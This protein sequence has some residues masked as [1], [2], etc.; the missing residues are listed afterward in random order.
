MS[1]RSQN[2]HRF[3]FSNFAIICDFDIDTEDFR[4]SIIQYTKVDL[5]WFFDQWLESQKRIDYSVKVKGNQVNFKRKS[6]SR[7]L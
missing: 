3:F 7:P 5:N 4:N 1:E 6:T 2:L